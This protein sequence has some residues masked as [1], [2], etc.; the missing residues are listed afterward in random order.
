VQATGTWALGK[1]LLPVHLSTSLKVGRVPWD[2]WPL[3]AASPDHRAGSAPLS[4][5]LQET[6]DPPRSVPLQTHLPA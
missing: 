2:G 3:L 5:P 4:D 6:P 1:I